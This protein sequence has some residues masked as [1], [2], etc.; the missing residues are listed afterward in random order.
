MAH[1]LIALLAAAW[2]L[3]V[4]DCELTAGHLGDVTVHEQVVDNYTIVL[5]GMVHYSLAASLQVLLQSCVFYLCKN[6]D[7][8]K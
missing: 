8:S 2:I 4:S 1:R 7:V 5:S 3:R 6:R